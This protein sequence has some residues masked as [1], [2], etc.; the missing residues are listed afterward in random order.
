M[1]KLSAPIIAVLSLL[2]ALP[3]ARTQTKEMNKSNEEAHARSSSAEELRERAQEQSAKLAQVYRTTSNTVVFTR[4]PGRT[5]RDLTTTRDTLSIPALTNLNYVS[6]R[7]DTILHTYVG[8][9]IVRI[10]APNGGIATLS[11]R[12]GT[13]A[14]NFIGTAFTDFAYRGINSVTLVDTPFTGFWKPDSNLARFQI[15]SMPAG[16]WIVSFVDTASGDSGKIIQWPLVVENNEIVPPNIVHT[17]ISDTLLTT[18][19][20]LSATITDTS[21]IASGTNGPKLW[22]KLSAAQSYASAN[23]DSASGSVRYFTIPGQAVGSVVQYY[24]S[25]QDNAPTNNSGTLPFGGTSTAAPPRPFQYK[26]GNT[27]AA[28]AYTVGA[29]GNFLTLDSAF[30]RIAVGIKGAVTLNLID[31][32]YTAPDRPGSRETCYAPDLV[33]ENGV[34]VKQRFDAPDTVGEMTLQGPIF[35]AGPNAR[36]TIRPLASRKVR[37]VGNGPSIIRLIDVSYVTID[38]QSTSPTATTSLTI[39]GTANGSSAILLEGNCDFNVIQ[40]V[41]INI[42]PSLETVGIYLK[43]GIFGVPDDNRIGGTSATTGNAI[44]SATDGVA[45]IGTISQPPSRNVVAYNALGTPT[46]SLGETGVYIQYANDT[47]INHNIVQNIRRAIPSY[48]TIAG[49]WVATKHLNTRIWNNVVKNVKLVSTT[50]SAT[51]AGVYIF[52]TSTD[53]TS[54]NYFN[55]VIYDIDHIATGTGSRI[56]GIYAS[57]GQ[58]DTIAFNTILLTGIGSAPSFTSVALWS[59]THVNQ[60][61]RNN[62]AIN[63]RNETGANSRALAIFKAFTTTT[64]SSNNNDLYVPSQTG[65][66]IGAVAATNYLTLADWQN[67]T[68]YDS[69][70]VSWNQAFRAGADLRIDTSVATPIDSMAVSLAGF[71]TDIDDEIRD[72]NRPDIGVDEFTLRTSP[73]VGWTAQASG[74]TASLRSVKAVN[75]NVGWISANGGGILR[76]TDAGVTWTSVGGGAIGTGNV[77]CITAVNENVALI[78]STPADTAWIL[79]T[80]NGGGTWTRVFTQ[81]GGFIDAIHM[82]DANNGIALGDPVGGTW[83]IARTTDGGATWT[84]MATEPAQVGTDAGWINALQVLNNNVWFFGTNNSK[85]Y[86]TTDGGQSWTSSA[87]TALNSYAL[88]FNDAAYGVAGFSDGAVNR[89][90]NGGGA[91]TPIAVPG[92]STIYGVTGAGVDFWLTKGNL[93]YRS[94]DRGATWATDYTSTIGTSLRHMNFWRSGST[95]AGWVVSSTGGVARYSGTITGVDEPTSV[96]ETFV[97]QQNYPNPFNPTTTIRYGLPEA[98]RVNLSIYNLLGQ[99]VAELTNEAQNAGY[100]N[101]IWN[102]RNQSGSQVATGVYFYR[103]EATPN[104]GAPFVSLKKALLLK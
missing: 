79:R 50:A 49:L 70:S 93:I 18:P 99:R 29:G 4:R 19:R 46:D 75:Q 33:H 48:T 80:T 2:F 51:A 74:S 94:T 101:V 41:I 87:T 5:I 3:H 23:P 83:T 71:T 42:P 44:Q 40:R 62:I 38:G 60:V 27:L 9:M 85:I 61:W 36:I 39:N 89:S 26:I 68:G 69:A 84:R 97:L 7:L 35:G 100:Y 10:E 54:G 65:S 63:L 78:G 24:I 77:H 15:A 81:V 12:R 66:F 76:T 96:P 14:D 64:L 53:V 95:V 31:T 32:L 17:K 57:T 55:N 67:A 8:D 47:D 30:A 58:R 52:G 28:G 1:K 82:F 104:G 88:W 102:G 6:I 72:L 59:N 25:A 56:E 91:W 73:P 45:I 43:A 86:K 21:G 22:W 20:I 13:S 90:V 37:I 11:N 16:N 34:Q 92:T 98:A 103:I